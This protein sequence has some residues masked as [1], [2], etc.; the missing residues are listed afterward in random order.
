[1]GNGITNCHSQPE[2]QLTPTNRLLSYH[3]TGFVGDYVDA[4]NALTLREKGI[5]ELYSFDPHYDRID[6]LTSL[7]P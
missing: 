4:F 3:A 2:I 7:E 6:W 5:E 1:M